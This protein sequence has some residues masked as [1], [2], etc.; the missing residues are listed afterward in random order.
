MK[1]PVIFWKYITKIFFFYF[2]LVLFVL[3]SLTLLLN[4][5]EVLRRSF[6]KSLLFGDLLSLI[7]FKI[8]LLVQHTLPFA[9]LIGA[10]ITISILNRGNELIAARSGSIS[11]W[12][13][14][15]P[16]FISVFTIGLITITI[17][18]PFV[19]TIHTKYISIEAK[20]LR[21]KENVITISD[22]GIWLKD[23]SGN[24]VN[25]I[26]HAKSFYERG[27]YL[28]EITIFA[29][30]DDNSLTTR[31]EADFG[32]LK[33][34]DLILNDVK[35]FKPG[36]ILEKYKQYVVNTNIAVDHLQ[37]SLATPEVVSFWDLYKFITKI[38]KAGFSSLKHKFYFYNL[39]L[40]PFFFVAL[41]IVSATFS[42]SLPRQGKLGLMFFITILI[43]FAIQI[44]TKITYTLSM[45]GAISLAL[46]ATAPILICFCV[47]IYLLLHYE[48]G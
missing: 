11:A 12:N 45:S 2:L 16:I 34:N 46:G 25:K 33:K 3:T 15:T 37:N 21:N 29:L 7:T 24:K 43:G 28:S 41:V 6:S 10:S 13:F 47:G 27:K 8:P 18:N 9:I 14:L 23:T 44:I 26:I 39:I 36:Q 30:S 35:I 31:I 19:A 20:F 5:L 1:I 4:T 22:S 48:D 40:M 42:L 17:L 38:E 32:S